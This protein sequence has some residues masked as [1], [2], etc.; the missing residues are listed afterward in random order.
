MAVFKLVVSTGFAGADHIDDYE[1]DDETL[2]E[3][4]PEEIEDELQEAVTDFMHN[5][6][7]CF[8]AV[9]ETGDNCGYSKRVTEEQVETTKKILNDKGM[10]V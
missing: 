1:I 9:Y 3:M 6:I 4:T 7:D 5:Q 8:W 10:N 2:K